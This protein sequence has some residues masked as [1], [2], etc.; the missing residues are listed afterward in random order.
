M[1]SPKSINHPPSSPTCL[2][3]LTI[4]HFHKH[5]NQ[6]TQSAALCQFHFQFTI[7]SIPNLPCSLF[8]PKSQPQLQLIKQAALCP[9]LSPCSVQIQRCYCFSTLPASINNS[10]RHLLHSS[11]RATCKFPVTDAARTQMPRHSFSV[12]HLCHDASAVP[13]QLLPP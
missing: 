4:I 9:P 6:E 13:K 3:F 12:T 2:P 7:S 1:Q 8:N 5:H 11:H 10:K